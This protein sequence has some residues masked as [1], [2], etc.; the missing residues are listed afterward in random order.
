MVR[1]KVFTSKDARKVW[2]R[3]GLGTKAHSVEWQ[4][5]CVVGIVSTFG[6]VIVPF[7]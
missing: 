2:D 6:N 1:L 3:W 5:Y 7:K 4:L